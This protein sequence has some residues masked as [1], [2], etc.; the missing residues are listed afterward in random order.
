ML[1]D[2]ELDYVLSLINTYFKLGYK[3]Y[4]VNTITDNDVIY[5]IDVYIS[6]EEIKA[7]TSTTFDLTNAI[8]I[9]IDSSNR[10]SNQYN[11][12]LHSRDILVNKSLTDI[13]VVDDAEFVYTNATVSTKDVTLVNPDLLLNNA[14]SYNHNVLL[15]SSILITSV[16][17]LYLFFA[18]ILRLR[19]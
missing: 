7:V 5:D 17:F 6:K 14:D 3:Y 8:H 12:S 1:S 11:Q 2:V 15:G 18:S 16:I 9:K 10:N 4:L 13:V 19:K